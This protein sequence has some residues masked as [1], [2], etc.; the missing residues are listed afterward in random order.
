MNPRKQIAFVATLKTPSHADSSGL[1]ASSC[2]THC[3]RWWA[4]IACAL[5]I[6][7]STGGLSFLGCDLSAQPT[8]HT[9]AVTTRSV[10]RIKACKARAKIQKERTGNLLGAHDGSGVLLGLLLLSSRHLQA[11]VSNIQTS[12]FRSFRRCMMQNLHL[13]T[14]L[15]G[16]Y[17]VL[18]F[19]SS[20]SAH[21]YVGQAAAKHKLTLP[22]CSFKFFSLALSRWLPR[23]I[24][25]TFLSWSG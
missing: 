21:I 14:Q 13:E 2:R 3:S 24:L 11:S 10:Y 16:T 5:G 1:R 19:L 12:E 4:L 23:A 20:L 8:E 6:L 9:S 22:A 25:S 17:G 15:G 18:A 7:F